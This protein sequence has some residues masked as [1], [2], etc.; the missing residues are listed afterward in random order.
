MIPA[1]VDTTTQK[2]ILTQ[3]DKTGLPAGSTIDS[4]TDDISIPMTSAEFAD[5]GQLV[6]AVDE[7]TGVNIST[8]A[9]SLQ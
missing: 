4:K 5:Y 3:I 8:N 6:S 1:K 7:T 2:T 9:F